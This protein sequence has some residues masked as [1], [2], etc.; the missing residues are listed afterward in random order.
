[1]ATMAFF[2]PPLRARRQYLSARNVFFLAA[3]DMAQAPRGAL[4]VRCPVEPRDC[5]S[6]SVPE[7]SI[8]QDHGRQERTPWFRTRPQASE[9]ALPR[10]LRRPTP[11]ADLLF[12]EHAQRWLSRRVLKPRTRE[13]Y[14][15]LRTIESH[16]DQLDESRNWRSW[17]EMAHPR[18]DGRSPALRPPRRRTDSC[19]IL[20]HCAPE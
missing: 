7:T 4:E 15:K 8:A 18:F 20:R 17:S 2:M 5:R 9:R 6:G 10:Q 14:G 19:D 16:H 1:M 11:S 12:G 3:I 13:H